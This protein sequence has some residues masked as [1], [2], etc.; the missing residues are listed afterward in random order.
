MVFARCSFVMC[1]PFPFLCIKLGHRLTHSALP[2]E[3]A[4]TGAVPDVHEL[5][6]CGAGETDDERP[7]VHM[8]VVSV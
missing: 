8:Y 6:M 5:A 7:D 3:K 2:T 1:T 4:F